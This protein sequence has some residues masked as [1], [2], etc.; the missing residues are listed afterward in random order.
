MRH[1]RW[2]VGGRLCQW[3]V[4]ALGLLLATA[5]QALTQDI[6]GQFTLT[7][8]GLVLNRTTNTFDSTVTLRNT[9]GAPVLAPISAVVGGLPSGI[10]LANKSGDA[11]DGKPF[12]SPMAAG[13]LLPNGGTLSFVLKFANPS[14]VSFTSSLQILYTVEVPADAPKLL[15]AIATGGTS[16]YLVGRAE[17]ASLANR[18]ITVQASFSQTCVVGTLVNGAPVGSAIPAKTDANGYF[19]VTVPGINPGDSVAVKLASPATT[20]SSQCLVSSRDNDSWPKAFL[21]DG[22]APTVRDFIDTPGKARWYKFPVTPG[23]RIDIKLSGLPADYDLAVFKD[24][25]QAFASQFSPDTARTSDLL[26][27]TAEYAPSIFSPSIFSPSIF[28]PSI[29][30]PDAYSPST[31]SP[32]IFS[33]SIFSPSIFSPS[34]F[35]PSIFSPSIFSPSIFSPSI[36]SP[37]I[38][39]PSIFS[40]SIFSKDEVAQAFSTAQSRTIIAVSATGGL[41]DEATVVNTWNRTGYFYVRVTGRSGAFNTSLPFTLSVSK[42]VT[43]CTTVTDFSV[44]KR[45]PVAASGLKTV[46]LTDSSKVALDLALPGPSGDTLR[47]KLSALAGRGE[48]SGVV[49]DVSNDDHVKALRQQAANNP[50]CPFAKNLVAE[51]IKGIVDSYRTNPLQYVVIVGND[52]AIPFFRSPDQSG[53]GQ[54]SGYVPPVQSNSPSEASLRL[55][56]VLSQDKYGS[57]TT[58]SLPW[59]DFPVPNLAVGRLVET[60]TEIAGVI[61]AYVATNAVVAPRSSLV[62]GYDFLEDAANVVKSELDAGTG[63]GGDALITP[64]GKSPQDSA[65]W[66][67]TQLGQKLFGSRHDV[68]FL[69]GHFSANSALAADFKTSLLTTDLAASTTDFAN[70]IVF[71]AGCHAGYNLVDGDAIAG[72]TLPLDWAQAFARKK[73]TLIAGTGYQYGDTDFLEY[74]ERLYVNFARQLRAGS[75]AVAVGDALVQAK[76]AYLAATPDLRGLHEKALLESALFGLPMLAVNMPAGRTAPPGGPGAVAAT[77][78]NSGPA[79][80]LGLQTFD[81]GVAP[82]LKAHT[83]TLKNVT[84]SADVDAVW[85]SGLDD[86]VVSK[87]GEPALPL[88][89][90]DVTP[91]D[92]RLVLRGIGYRGGAF[93]DSAAVY[94]FTGAPSTESRTVHVP[95][96]SPVFYP[97][98][99][100][101]PNY[102][103]ALSGAGGTQLLITPAQH[104]AASVANGTS[105]QRKHTG[106][107]LRLFYSGNLSQAALSDGPSIVAVDAQRDASGVVFAAQV[108]GDPAAAI[109]QVWVTYTG[110]GSSAWTPLDLDQCVRSGSANLLPAACGT[111]EDSRVWKGRL[112]SAPANPKYFVQAV[113][114]VGLVSRNDNLGAY[115]GI[116][117]VTPTAT[118]LAL[119]APPSSATVGDSPNVTARLSYAGGG[120][121]AGKVISV[122]V[123]G[124]ARLATTGSDGSVTVKMPV[125]ANPGSYQITAAFAGD[126]VFQASSASAPLVVN[127]AAV[128]SAVVANG[129]AS[130]GI[131]ISGALGGTAAGLQQ[132]PVAFTVNGPSGTTTVYAI[133]DYLGN[134]TFPPPS[135]LPPGTYTV[136][137]ATFGGDGTYAPTTIVF[138]TPQQITVPKTNQG[139]TFDP[140]A[141]KSVRRSG[142]PGVRKREPFGTRRVLQGERQLHG[143]GQHRPPDRPAEAARSPRIRAATPTTIRRRRSHGVFQSS[144]RRRWSR[145]CARCRT[146]RWPTASPTRLPS[147]KLSRALRRSTSR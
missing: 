49:V 69:A 27:L 76:L 105:T 44:T 94:P 36:F 28:S 14:R 64:N 109:Y 79:Q 85:L 138:S 20:P 84:G 89:V 124:A 57:K 139:I 21:L 135:G 77:P 81:L 60:A 9:S 50:A 145:S 16:A 98:T 61:D 130:A 118:I 101:T 128:T 26:K 144:R 134:A 24:I 41:S 59:N 43:S 112:S 88:V 5:A 37:S 129:A 23:Q 74:S 104:R 48:V 95:F 70:S 65:S 142:L 53:L 78:V 17:G 93:I 67:A 66:T 123:G 110:D 42:G 32:S 117:S 90:I 111:T 8:S 30:S 116:S 102:F 7:R 10:T 119:V 146:R 25:G 107:N 97:T 33:P 56:F 140:L 58:I 120:G 34:I 62:T 132:V 108:V 113:N 3:A 141:G 71:S 126:D 75:G 13:T 114:G 122:G 46:I 103:G 2:Q 63:A 99:M 19:S 100:W 52:D 82:G 92:P 18:D 72:V 131:N 6:T 121:L 55:D 47:A 35:S 91:G 147:A 31:F 40:P 4:I 86:A 133:T 83:K 96:L 1:A 22:S 80:A 38:F 136:T 127:R 87:P 45:A 125:V 12:V 73:A 137:Q 11:A 51:E 143:D 39:S 68:I 115:F 54:E 29:F 15:A 106:L